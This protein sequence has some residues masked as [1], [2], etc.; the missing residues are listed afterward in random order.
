MALPLLSEGRGE[1]RSE[2]TPHFKRSEFACHCGCGLD[3]PDPSLVAGLESL[4]GILG[5][6]VEI[7]S[8]CRCARHNVTIGGAQ[9]SQHLTGKAADI[10]VGGMTPDALY[11]IAKRIPQFRGF[12]VDSERNM[13][14][15]DVRQMTARW[16][17]HE[18]RTA[19]WNV[20]E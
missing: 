13:L 7:L 6:P 17:Y 12:G 3:N 1:S 19:P 8:G 15:V 18:G 5:R 11:L 10:R 4:R 14:H 9:G 16:R 20:T 2:M